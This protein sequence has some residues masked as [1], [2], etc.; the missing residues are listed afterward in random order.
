MQKVN[1]ELI[2]L[3]METIR[4]H[5][6][7]YQLNVDQNL[8]NLIMT[9]TVKGFKPL[10]VEKQDFNLIINNDIENQIE[11]FGMKHWKEIKELFNNL[12]ENLETDDNLNQSNSG[13]NLLLEKN[14]YTNSTNDE[15]FI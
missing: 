7:K 10:T 4:K 14:Y 11:N 1:Y 2:Q 8:N 13:Y 3:F 9:L 12:V 15:K 5:Q 6:L